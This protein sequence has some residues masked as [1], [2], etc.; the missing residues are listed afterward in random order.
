MSETCNI[1]KPNFNLQKTNYYQAEAYNQFA[2]EHYYSWLY[3]LAV[4]RFRWQGLPKTVD[5][6]ILERELFKSGVCSISRV[7][8][9]DIWLGL[10][11][12]YEDEL[13][14]YG[15]PT[16]WRCIGLNGDTF[17]SDWENG[18][19][20]YNSASYMPIAQSLMLIARK[21]AH[22]SR[23]EDVNMAVQMKPWIITAKDKRQKQAIIN[24]FNNVAI[25]NPMVIGG[26]SLMEGVEIHTQS[27]DV[28]FKGLELA[29]ARRNTFLEAFQIL[30]IEA[31]AYEKGERMIEAEAEGNNTPTNVML[32]DA[33]DGRRGCGTYGLEYLNDTF[34]FNASVVFNR[35]Y[36]SY[37][38]NYVADFERRAQ[39][40]EGVLEQQTETEVASNE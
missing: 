20:V 18:T 15:R 22:N 33:L 11:V 12:A 16:K 8:N 29:N 39:L 3:R 35:D 2:F 27:L 34:G 28:P 5:T 32:L 23:T 1:I 36:E 10:P 31:L 14:I 38:F 21:L 13:N 7:P 26:A 37:N 4:N 24:A 9:T 19:L 40:G 25:G 6:T 17:E 30:G